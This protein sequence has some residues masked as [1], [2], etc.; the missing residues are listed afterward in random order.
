MKKHFY[1]HIIEVESIYLAL[2][3]LPLSTPEKD[4]LSDLV[5]S[6]V[7]HTILDLILSHLSPADKKKFIELHA[8]HKHDEVWELLNKRIDNVEAKI[9][10][11]VAELKKKL[12]SDIKAAK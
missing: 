5:E 1:D 6:Q 11:T 9:T 8:S 4:E 2:E 10:S 3:D 7:H 12:R